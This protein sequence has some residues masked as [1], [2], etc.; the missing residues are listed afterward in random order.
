MKKIIISVILFIAVGISSCS[1]WDD[2]DMNSLFDIPVAENINIINGA[3]PK[4]SQWNDIPVFL[5]NDKS[6]NPLLY[7]AIN[8]VKIATNLTKSKLYF[9]VQINGTLP[10]GSSAYFVFLLSNDY[11]CNGYFISSNLNY[12][13]PFTLYKYNI[14]NS[15]VLTLTNYS[16]AAGSG[17]YNFEFVIDI[18]SEFPLLNDTF[19]VSV[20]SSIGT[21]GPNTNFPTANTGST[22]K[23]RW[24][25]LK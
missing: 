3:I 2:V 1:M 15:N 9:F 16:V 13:P 4:P 25:K 18:P 10:G 11:S 23:A 20:Y 12:M 24:V 8:N 5:E 22:T 14:C 21:T 6:K 17:N 19:L 7:Q